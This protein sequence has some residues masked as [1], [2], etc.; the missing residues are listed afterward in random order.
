MMQLESREVIE[1]IDR[2]RRTMIISITC[3]SMD[4]GTEDAHKV[5]QSLVNTINLYTGEIA[6]AIQEAEDRK[7]GA[8]VDGMAKEYADRC[9][10]CKHWDV[11]KKKCDAWDQRGSSGPCDLFE[12]REG[13]RWYTV[14][15]PFLGRA[16]SIASYTR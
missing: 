6:R 5:A 15:R 12:T 13:E 4:E 16:N 14:T 2:M 10:G 11:P 1:I 7:V 8:M 3:A 9:L